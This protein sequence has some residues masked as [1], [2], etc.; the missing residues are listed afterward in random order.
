MYN[1]FRLL[2]YSLVILLVGISLTACQRSTQ[3]ALIGAEVPGIQ[4]AITDN[5]C[6]SVEISINDQITWVNEDD[7]EHLIRVESSGEQK[8][9]MFA[10]ADLG[11]GDVSSLTFPEAGTYS[12]VCSVDEES[13]GTIIVHP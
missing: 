13:T 7:Q 5:T 10:Y 12:Y 1:H 9:R 3:T 6:P 8:D 11:P 2:R 4:V